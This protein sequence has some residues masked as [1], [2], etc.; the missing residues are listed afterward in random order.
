M[1]ALWP[2]IDP[3]QAEYELLR[4]LALADAELAGPI[5][6]RFAQQGL[7]GLIAW[8]R[9]EPS[10]SVTMIGAKRP[11]WTPDSDPRVDALAA[12]YQLVL[13]LCSARTEA[14]RVRR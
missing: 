2:V 11:P 13:E 3:I 8:R 5:A 9:A 10:F 6:S 4:T 14:A 7:A 1:R 12:A